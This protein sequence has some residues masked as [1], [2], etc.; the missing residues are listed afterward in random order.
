MGRQTA[1][2]TGN[3]VGVDFPGGIDAWFTGVAVKAIDDR[4]TEGQGVKLDKE[5]KLRPES[6]VK[7]PDYLLEMAYKEA[8]SSM[9]ICSHKTKR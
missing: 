7:S 6:L 8:A 2:T 1:G 3:V 4:F 5:I 9:V